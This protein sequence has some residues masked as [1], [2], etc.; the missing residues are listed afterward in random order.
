MGSFHPPRQNEG[1]FKSK[2]KGGGC[3]RN[4]LILSLDSPFFFDF[5]VQTFSEL[6]DAVPNMEATPHRTRPARRRG[7]LGERAMVSQ[8]RAEGRQV[9]RVVSLGPNLPPQYPPSREPTNIAMLMML[10]ENDDDN[11]DDDDVVIKY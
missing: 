4:K 3:P 10:A 9:R 1:F 8:P 11:D 2:K 7:R 5:K 6:N